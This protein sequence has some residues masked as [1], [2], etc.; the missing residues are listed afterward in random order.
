MYLRVIFISSEWI[1]LLF[2]LLFPIMVI[3]F[4]KKASSNDL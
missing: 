4:L 3:F 2:K 1:D